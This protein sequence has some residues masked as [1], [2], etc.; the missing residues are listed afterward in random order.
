[1]ITFPLVTGWV[2]TRGT[3]SGSVRY[4]QSIETGELLADSTRWCPDTEEEENEDESDARKWKV[5]IYA[6][7]R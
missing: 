7:V 4:A 1:M 2:R 5:D 3:E 6:I